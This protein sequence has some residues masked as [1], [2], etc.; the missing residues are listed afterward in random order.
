M[1]TVTVSPKYQV[2]IPQRVRESLGIKPGQKLDV[3]EYDGRIEFVLVRQPREM[4]GFLSGIDTS[5]DRD[6]DR[7]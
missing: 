1:K 4:R 7:V 2:V 5:V 3:F 6:P